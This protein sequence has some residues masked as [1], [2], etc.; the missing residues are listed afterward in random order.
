MS[1]GSSSPLPAAAVPVPIDVDLG[2]ALA[3]GRFGPPPRDL[4]A[5]ESAFVSLVESSGAT[6]DLAWD[7]FY[8]ATLARLEGG[9]DLVAGAG[10]LATFSRI[11]ARAIAL[12]RGESVLDVGTC[13]GFLP[14][15][16]AGRPGAP[17]LHAL[18]VVPA[19]VELAARQSRRLGRSVCW[20]VADGGRLPLQDASVDTVLL[21]HVIEHLAPV[22]AAAL[23]AEARRVAARR[24]VVAV[25]VEPEPDPVFGHL[26]VFELADLATLGVAGGWRRSLTDADGAWL[27]LDRPCPPEPGHISSS[28][29]W[30]D[31]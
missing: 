19:S 15:L 28:P 1:P 12:A 11:W 23:L 20:T 27:V 30:P 22:D 10:T 26:Q 6:R 31:R 21:L 7:A 8:D 9:G 18:D 25:P 13:F 2:D 5:F 24:V 17:R 14:L 4:A 3:S 29:S 16:W